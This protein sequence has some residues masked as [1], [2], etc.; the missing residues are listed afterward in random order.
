VCIDIDA[1][2][3]LRFTCSTNHLHNDFESLCG[4]YG[5]N[6]DLKVAQLIETELDAAA[7][8]E[9]LQAF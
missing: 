4:E 8:D 3:M 1:I 6:N 9:E 2:S 5:Y 7:T